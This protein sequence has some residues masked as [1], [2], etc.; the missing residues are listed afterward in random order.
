MRGTEPGSAAINAARPSGAIAGVRVMDERGGFSPPSRVAWAGGRLL[1]GEESGS[2]SRSG[3][4]DG[5]AS[6]D[7]DGDGLWLVPGFV[8]AH[9]HVA[10]HDFD[11]DA[12]SV[13]TPEDTSRLTAL[14]LE[15]I[16]AEG[17]TA[18]RDAGG[19]SAADI[20]ALP[21]GPRP[22]LSLSHRL[23]DRA[24]ADEAGGLDAAVEAVLE[25]GADWV[26]IVATA[27]VAAP[28][29]AALEPHFS[30][31]EIADAVSRAERAGAGVLVHAWGGD[32]I[33]FA[34]EA[35]VLSIEHAIYLTAEQA[36]RAAERATVLVPTLRIY[37][38]VLE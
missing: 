17:F 4:P 29:N 2:G 13:R 32:A 36:A 3:V 38:L 18:V 20:A 24:A 12:R 33:D 15:S 9:A 10:W 5:A 16:V 34:I 28:E 27:G 8:D 23:I 35:G 26:K 1:C 7:L 14:A 19:L 30:A 37:R 6:G 21:P 25:E 11:A 22:D 31:A